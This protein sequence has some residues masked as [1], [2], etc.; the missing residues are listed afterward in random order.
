MQKMKKISELP[1]CLYEKCCA[2]FYYSIY[3]IF[4]TSLYQLLLEPQVPQEE[5]PQLCLRIHHNLLSYFQ[6]NLYVLQKDQNRRTY[7]RQEY[8]E[9]F[10]MDLISCHCV[11]RE[12][13]QCSMARYS[14]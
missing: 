5:Q 12:T 8:Q 7:C 1:E 10:Q 14:T 2:S 9:S 3:S 6:A 11:K 13:R 4:G